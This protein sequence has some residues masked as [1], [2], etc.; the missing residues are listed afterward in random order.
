MSAA[1]C[2]GYEFDSLFGGFACFKHSCNAIERGAWFSGVSV[3]KARL[4]VTVR[5]CSFMPSNMPARGTIVHPRV[6]YRLSG[7]DSQVN[8]KV[9]NSL[10]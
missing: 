4:Y 9:A 7:F 10:G 8:W 5:P 6:L 1:L 2:L 3:V